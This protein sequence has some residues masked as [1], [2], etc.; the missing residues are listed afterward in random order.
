MIVEFL[1]YYSFFA[2]CCCL[3]LLKKSIE[4][5]A[6]LQAELESERAALESER[7]ALKSERAKAEGVLRQ[8]KHQATNLEQLMYENIALKEQIQQQDG[9]LVLL[10]KGL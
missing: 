8:A 9:N 3:W 1:L 7:A 6:G 5:T 2:T 10:K 4:T